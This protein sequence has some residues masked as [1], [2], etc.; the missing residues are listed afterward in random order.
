MI[1]KGHNFDIDKLI[2]PIDIDKNIPKKR[3]NGLV[4]RDSQIEIL[5]SYKIN[6]ELFST[7]NSLINEIESIIDL[8]D[9]DTEDLEMLSLELSE[10]NYYNYTHK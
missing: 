1:V 3:K 5:N 2:E 7:L 10:M 8:S 9:G 6:Y 4:L